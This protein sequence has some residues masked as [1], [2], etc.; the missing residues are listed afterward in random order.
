[1]SPSD[2][3]LATVEDPMFFLALV[4]NFFKKDFGSD[5]TGKVGPRYIFAICEKMPPASRK[6]LACINAFQTQDKKPLEFVAASI[7]TEVSTSPRFQKLRTKADTFLSQVNRSVSTSKKDFPSVVGIMTSNVV[8]EEMEKIATISANKPLPPSASSLSPPPPIRPAAL[9]ILVATKGS[10]P[11]WN[12]LIGIG[13]YQEEQ[14]ATHGSHMVFPN[15]AIMELPH[16]VL[17]ESSELFK[18][19]A[20]PQIQKLESGN[21]VSLIKTLGKYLLMSNAVTGSE[22]T[23]YCF[24]YSAADKHSQGK[25]NGGIPKVCQRI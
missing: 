17:F 5:A 2:S 18:Q 16:K 23:F 7:P 15:G 20:D 3:Y 13:K 11:T 25:K 24:P 1:M 10:Y 14:A 12:R 6:P 8:R 4:P 19:I 9:P 21:M 22:L